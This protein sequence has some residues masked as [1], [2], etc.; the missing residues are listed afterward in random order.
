MILNL[1]KKEI[2]QIYNAIIADGYAALRLR[3]NNSYAYEEEERDLK[4]DF[5]IL[6]KLDKANEDLKYDNRKK[7]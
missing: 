5:S 4:I 2:K 6:K 3:D 7:E 1:T